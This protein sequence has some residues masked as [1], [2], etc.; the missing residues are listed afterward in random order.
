MNVCFFVR[1]SEVR[2]TIVANLSV[3]EFIFVMHSVCP[4]FCSVSAVGMNAEYY[5]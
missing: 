2:N 5:A 4:F 1:E 3:S